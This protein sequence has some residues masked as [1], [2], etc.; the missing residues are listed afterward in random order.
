M[1]GDRVCMR[2]VTQCV[3]TESLIKLNCPAGRKRV[4]SLVVSYSLHGGRR[5]DQRAPRS[6]RVPTTTTRR[7]PELTQA[8]ADTP[9]WR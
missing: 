7:R 3:K 5:W 2:C 1:S 6:E 4:E 8:L 9:Q